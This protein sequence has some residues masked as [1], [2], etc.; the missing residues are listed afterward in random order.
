M[1]AKRYFWQDKQGNI[2]GPFRSDEEG[3]PHCGDVIQHYRLL[4]NTSTSTLGRELDKTARWVQQMEKDNA[5]PELISR[6]KLIIKALGI[7][8]ILLFPNLYGDDDLVRVG[9]QPNLPLTQEYRSNASGSIDLRYC[10]ELLQLY[11][12]S[13]HANG[14]QN[15]L[16]SLEEKIH[17]LQG[18]T[19]ENSSEHGKAL[20]LLCR[21]H[22]LIALIAGE[23]DDFERAFPHLHRAIAIAEEMQNPELQ[24]VCLFR[25]GLT[26][27]AQGNFMK[28]ATDLKRSALFEGTIPTTLI[29]RILLSTGKAEARAKKSEY[30]GILNVFDKAEKI[31]Q[32]GRKEEDTHF[33]RLNEGNYHEHRAAALWAMGNLVEAADELQEAHETFPA[34]QARRHN[35]ID[36]MQAELAANS[37]EDII[38]ASVALR[39][40]DVAKQLEMTRNINVVAGV[41]RQ[42]RQGPYGKSKDVRELGE[43]LK[44]WQRKTARQPH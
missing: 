30:R 25:R 12:N 40:F 43:K 18:F 20:A 37:S 29:G 34:D 27:S 21:Y 36:A 23:R 13:Y 3:N 39:A 2:Y 16:Q 32:A 4:R 31:I 42:L 22:Q 9:N 38:A 44:E 41:Y 33:I 7:P 24:A 17:I 35:N 19:V 26:Y 10:N 6:R 1:E 5:V 14:G 11:W 15:L 28:A 8:P